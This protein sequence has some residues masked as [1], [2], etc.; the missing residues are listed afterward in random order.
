MSLTLY[1]CD[2]CDLGCI[3]GRRKQSG[4]SGLY[5]A[6]PAY[7]EPV[8][9]PFFTPEESDPDWEPSTLPH[10]RKLYPYKWLVEELSAWIDDNWNDVPQFIIDAYLGRVINHNSWQAIKILSLR[11]CGLADSDA[12]KKQINK[13][14]KDEIVNDIIPPAFVAGMIYAAQRYQK[15]LQDQGFKPD[16]KRIKEDWE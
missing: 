12:V 13:L 3:I 4:G 16:Y 11:E 2:G 5:G 8:F 9:C 10:D 7:C 15:L 1:K 6:D 14:K